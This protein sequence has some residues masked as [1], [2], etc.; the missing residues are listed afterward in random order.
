MRL[1]QLQ[2]WQLLITPMH[3]H[4]QSQQLRLVQSCDFLECVTR[5]MTSQDVNGL[6]SIQGLIIMHGFIKQAGQ[7]QSEGSILR[8]V[9]RCSH[10]CFCN[11]GWGPL[12]PCTQDTCSNNF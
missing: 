4:L 11:I 3:L 2:S 10:S 12:P 9:S 1:K 8:Q 7:V 6:H 5:P